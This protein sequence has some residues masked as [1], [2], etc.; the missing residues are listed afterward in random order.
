MWLHGIGLFP[1]RLNNEIVFNVKIKVFVKDERKVE[2]N[3]VY[4][5]YSSQKYIADVMMSSL[6]E[7]EPHTRCSVIVKWIK[8]GDSREGYNPRYEVTS[9]G[10]TFNVKFFP[11]SVFAS[12]YF[13]TVGDNIPT[14][15]FMSV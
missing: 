3:R 14:L 8:G 12:Q 1:H 7:I 5:G 2:I 13:D 6:I 4:N 10:D 9:T 11:K 15:Y